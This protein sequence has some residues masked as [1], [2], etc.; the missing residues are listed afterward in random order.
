MDKDKGVGGGLNVGEG[1]WAGQER[2]MGGA[3]S[4]QL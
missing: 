4:G 2:V 3:E 1:V